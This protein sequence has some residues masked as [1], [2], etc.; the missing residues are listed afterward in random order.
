[1]KAAV[2][3]SGGKDSVWAA[4]TAVFD[5]HDVHLLTVMTEPYSMMFHFPNLPW[6]RLQ[7]RL[8]GLPHSFVRKDRLE[9]I[10]QEFDILYTG[11]VE[12]SYQRFALDKTADR[13]G[14]KVRHPLWLKSRQCVEEITRHLKVVFVAVA[15]EGMGKDLLLKEVYPMDGI[16]PFFEGGEAET[17]VVDA[18]LFSHSIHIKDWEIYWEKIRGYAI[19]R[20]VELRNKTAHHHQ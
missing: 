4:H 17:F 8:M 1:M 18:P 9:M 16:H 15:A 2:L 5:G 19:I 14:I 10:L 20:Q 3:F 12:S 11:A 7:A 13:L 6:T